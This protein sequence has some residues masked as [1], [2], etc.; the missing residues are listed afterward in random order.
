MRVKFVLLLFLVLISANNIF[1]ATV[2]DINGDG[3]VDMSEAIK[4][5]QVTSG[6]SQRSTSGDINGDRKIDL[7]ETIYALQVMSGQGFSCDKKHFSLCL[8]KISCTNTSGYWWRNKTCNNTSETAYNVAPFANAG[9]DQ[10]IATGDIVTLEGVDSG[11]VDGDPIYYNWHFIAVPQGSNATLSDS[12]VIN[13]T[14]TTDIDGTYIV[15]LVVNDDLE[16]SV[17]DTITINSY[18]DFSSLFY[19]SSGSSTV[20][21]NGYLQSGSTF[22]I[23]LDNNS[24]SSFIFYRAE[25]YNGTT[26]QGYTEDKSLLGGDKLIPGE[27]IGIKWTLPSTQYDNGINFK[28][29]FNQPNTVSNFMLSYSSLGQAVYTLLPPSCNQNHLNLC[30]TSMDCNEKGGY[31]WSNNTCNQ[32]PP[33]CGSDN[34]MQCKFSEECINVGGNWWSNNTCMGVLESE[35]VVS[36]NGRVWMDRNLGAFRVA[37]SYDDKEAYGDLYQ[38]GRGTDGHEK[39][40]SGTTSIASPIDVPGHGNFITQTEVPFN[41]RV[42]END[43]LW[44]GLSGPNNPC[45]AE[46]R[47]PTEDEWNAEITSWNTSDIYGAFNSPLKIVEAGIRMIAGNIAMTG[48]KGQYWSSTTTNISFVRGMEVSNTQA[49]ISYQIPG[50][51]RSVR[52]IMN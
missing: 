22:S 26:I 37:T 31:W 46:F 16:Y 34:L 11:D 6:T 27:K 30:Q 13:P 17:E 45:P 44:Q 1:A 25:F 33:P 38:W 40:N 14:F 3:K 12:T 29:Y 20:N 21:I 32:E 42:P 10:K 24:S 51:G 49:I 9:T 48:Y 23:F 50:Y 47:L 5:I 19:V 15:G 2:G 7:S 8:T 39:R 43:S 18:S 4:T 41:W 35:T 52:C 28:L 36:S